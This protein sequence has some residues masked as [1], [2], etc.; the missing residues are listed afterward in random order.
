MQHPRKKP[1]CCCCQTAGCGGSPQGLLDASGCQ[2]SKT[3]RS[4]LKLCKRPAGGWTVAWR[5]DGTVLNPWGPTRELHDPK[6]IQKVFLCLTWA[7]FRD[8][9][10]AMRKLKPLCI[11]LRLNQGL[12]LD[13]CWNNYLPNQKL[14]N[15]KCTTIFSLLRFSKNHDSSFVSALTGRGLWEC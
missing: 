13:S 4:A 10:E 1:L 5:T 3:T 6:K 15:L 14:V 2:L 9:P 7:A 8:V 12:A 11:L